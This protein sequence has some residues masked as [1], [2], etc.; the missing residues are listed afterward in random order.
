MGGRD[1]IFAASREAWGWW[2]NG[3]IGKFGVNHSGSGLPRVLAPSES[4]PDREA[5][6]PSLRWTFQASRRVWRMHT[7]HDGV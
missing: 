3:A 2:R 5:D 1:S 6:D 4:L 7:S